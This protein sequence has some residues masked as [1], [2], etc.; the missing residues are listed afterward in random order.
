MT[1]Y[2]TRLNILN[3]IFNDIVNDK[4][5][6]NEAI[7]KMNSMTLKF[8]I[9]IDNF[10]FESYTI[11]VKYIIN[12]IVNKKLLY[13][14]AEHRMKILA[15]KLNL[16]VDDFISNYGG[17]IDNSIE[18]L[19]LSNGQVTIIEKLSNKYI[20][21]L[22]HGITYNFNFNTKQM[23]P[24]MMIRCS[25]H[26]ILKLFGYF[27][28]IMCNYYNKLLKNPSRI[29]YIELSRKYNSAI[30]YINQHFKID[31]PLIISPHNSLR[32]NAYKSGLYYCPL[33]GLN[34]DDDE[35]CFWK[36]EFITLESEKGINWI[37]EN[38]KNLYNRMVEYHKSEK[39]IVHGQHCSWL[40]SDLSNVAKSIN[41]FLS[42]KTFGGIVTPDNINIYC[43]DF[44]N[45]TKFGRKKLAY[46]N[47]TI[48][49]GDVCIRCVCIKTNNLQCNT[50]FNLSDSITYHQFKKSFDSYI[51]HDTFDD[52]NLFVQDP[53]NS[54]FE[55]LNSLLDP[56]KCPSIR[57]CSS[58]PIC[59]YV[60]TIENTEA[61]LNSNGNN[62]LL[63]H[64]S[65]VICGNLSCGHKYCTD[66]KLSHPGFICRG[67]PEEDDTEKDIQSC[68]ACGHI[69]NRISGCTCMTCEIPTCNKTWCWI[70][71]CIRYKEQD[72]DNINPDYLHYCMDINRYQS[73]PKWIN[74][75]DFIPYKNVPPV[76]QEN[77]DFIPA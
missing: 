42:H 70:C 23:I 45:Y 5:S 64:P 40:K 69:T 27:E 44:G 10:I 9:T 47:N 14:Q 7:D 26:R 8:N 74:N 28:N 15:T 17:L 4:L 48:S 20:N 21:I 18:S 49:V 62:P 72:P 19:S 65:D 25:S 52:D 59:N 34:Y 30:N 56:S 76:G 35:L 32:R 77:M 29:S 63:K 37:K 73:N 68:P 67:F 57:T 6:Y 33:L 66:C 11:I 43:R 71:R 38:N 31:L 46:F 1:Y 2:N 39:I 3:I 24:K 16:N 53:V 22:H 55:R 75:P 51:P 58:C 36:K 54:M 12:N 60:N 50:L 13:S 41:L 61:L